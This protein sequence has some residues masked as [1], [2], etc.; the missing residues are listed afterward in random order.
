[1]DSTI[2]YVTKGHHR[3]LGRD[4]RD[5]QKVSS[6]YLQSIVRNISGRSNLNTAVGSST[7]TCTGGGRQI[8]PGKE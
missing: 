3:S 1:M 5:F 6:F 7:A 8:M 2:K 4:S